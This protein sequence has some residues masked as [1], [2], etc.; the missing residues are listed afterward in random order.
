MLC[1]YVSMT[2]AEG[3]YGRNTQMDFS[4]L[5]SYAMAQNYGILPVRTFFDFRH[6]KLP[7]NQDKLLNLR[8]ISKV[9]VLSFLMGLTLMF[10]IMASYVLTWDKKELLLSS[11]SDQISFTA[12]TAEASSENTLMDLK[13]LVK[14]IRSKLEY[15]PRKVPD[16]K[17]VTETD[18]RVS[19]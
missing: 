15:T 9:K 4:Y 17:D 7:E 12:A 18:S 14:I 19:L 5:H 10:L 8:S 2:G 11:S 16:Q 3:K 13:L 1:L 6:T